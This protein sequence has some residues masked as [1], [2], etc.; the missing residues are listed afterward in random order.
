[1]RLILG[2]SSI[3]E[4]YVADENH[5]T[6]RRNKDNKVSMCTDLGHTISAEITDGGMEEGEGPEIILTDRHDISLYIREELS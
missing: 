2:T 1:M 3:K 5:R 4:T 6:W